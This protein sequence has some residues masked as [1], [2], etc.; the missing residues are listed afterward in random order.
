MY[1]AARVAG[2]A[3]NNTLGSLSSFL[4]I[5]M[6]GEESDFTTATRLRF[7]QHC[8]SMWGRICAI[9]NDKL[10]DLDKERHTDT[11]TRSAQSEAVGM[12]LDSLRRAHAA[13]VSSLLGEND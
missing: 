3:S 9:C 10:E 13:E 4:M 11:G 12:Q 7:Q 8:D 1:A 5:P 2:L 6:D